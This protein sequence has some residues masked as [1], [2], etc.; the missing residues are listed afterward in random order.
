MYIR[1]EQESTL[2][3]L[4][5]RV[6]DYRADKTNDIL[7]ELDAKELTPEQFNYIAQLSEI[8]KDSGT[9]GEMELGVFK[10]T[11]NKLKTYEKELIKC[12]V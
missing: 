8:L 2:I 10:I 4:T 3:D 7:V 9:V 12:S 11:I 5:D 1:G 6:K